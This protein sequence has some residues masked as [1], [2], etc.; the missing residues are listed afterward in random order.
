MKI[1]LKALQAEEIT[2]FV[3]NLGQSRYKANQIINWL[4]KKY[5]SSFTD[6]T[7]LSKS[8]KDIL[9]KKAFISNLKI[10]KVQVSKD[11]TH[12]F[13]FELEDSR[14]IE[15]VLIPDS[16]R[17]TLC[18]SSQVG[19]AMGC[20]FCI[21]GSLK[22]KRNLRAHEIFD[23]V[24]TV[25]RLVSENKVRLRQGFYSR[26]ITNIVFMGM[27]EP[28]NNLPEVIEAVRKLT[29]L[30][31]FSKRRITVSTCGIVPGID[32]LARGRTGV[33][34]AVSLN[35]V[36]DAARNKIMPVNKKYPLHKLV[37]ACRKYPLPPGRRITFEY[38]LL[39]GI[40]DSMD[41][42]VRL[43]RLLKGIRAKVNLIP[44]NEPVKNSGFSKPS[45]AGVLAFQKV[46]LDA[47][48]AAIIRKSRGRD[49]SAAC[50]QL[51]ALKWTRAGKPVLPSG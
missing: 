9:D 38:V 3:E 37:Q 2:E 15:S 35:A 33:N 36:T 28:L 22:L 14:T 41:D 46:L 8:F 48:I 4:Y 10:L 17:L 47:K 20:E 45:E 50:G 31:G 25:Q 18:I 23:Q 32:E 1:N 24:I 29:G 11:G 43:V 34:L 51:G 6:M 49:I 16:D 44:F 12:K 40:N 30:L 42:A 26:K 39:K 21:T 13:L 27:G 19:C 7:D 5:A